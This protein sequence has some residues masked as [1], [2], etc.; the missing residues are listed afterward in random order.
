MVALESDNGDAIACLVLMIDDLASQNNSLVIIET[1]HDDG[2]GL[3]SYM[4]ENNISNE[5]WG[6]W[7]QLLPKHLNIS[8]PVAVIPRSKPCSR[9]EMVKHYWCR[10]P[11]VRCRRN[12]H[13]S[14]TRQLRSRCLKNT[15]RLLP[16]TKSFQLKAPFIRR[17]NLSSI[18][19][20]ES[21]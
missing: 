13:G 10:S 15:S 7:V 6:S 21:T 9:R 12:I 3:F 14:R 17:L 5:D 4:E 18:K 2:C 11:W 19:E 20:W 1:F 8:M 16:T